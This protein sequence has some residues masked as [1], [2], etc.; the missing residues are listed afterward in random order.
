MVPLVRVGVG[1]G[2]VL[3]FWLVVAVEWS[4]SWIWSV[5]EFREVDRLG[6]SKAVFDFV[7]SFESLLPS[8]VVKTSLWELLRWLLLEPSLLP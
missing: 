8:S 2:E 5:F 6:L 4:G 3:D 1:V 7:M